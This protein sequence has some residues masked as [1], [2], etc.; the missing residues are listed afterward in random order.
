[1]RRGSDY[2]EDSFEVAG[3]EGNVL[4]K[5]FLLTR[6]K[7]SRSIRAALRAEARKLLGGWVKANGVDELFSDLIAGKV[8]KEL[9]QGLRKIYPLAVA[10]V[11][12]LEV[13][14]GDGN[15]E[16]VEKKSE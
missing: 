6:K 13:L 7:V 3:K 16:K 11:R 5:P 10:E 15:E 12:W 14:G 8:Q 1:M 9:N 4:V 2:V